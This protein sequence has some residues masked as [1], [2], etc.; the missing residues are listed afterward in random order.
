M[1]V[2][3]IISTKTLETKHLQGIF[4]TQIEPVSPALQVDFL[5][6]EPSGK[7]FQMALYANLCQWTNEESKKGPF[8]PW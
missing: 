1:D 5:P 4:S 7:V 3:I 2:M 6:A 8:L